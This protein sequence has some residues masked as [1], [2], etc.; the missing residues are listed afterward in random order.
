MHLPIDIMKLHCFS[1]CS[2]D[3]PIVQFNILVGGS[4]KGE[5]TKTLH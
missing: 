3:N 4:Y 1:I 2:A 5:Q